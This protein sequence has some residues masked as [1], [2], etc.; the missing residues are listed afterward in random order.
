VSS[1]PPS[2]GEHTTKTFSPWAERLPE[3][4]TPE[5]LF[6]ETKWCSLMSYGLTAELLQEVLPM[7]SALH[8]STIRERSPAV[9]PRCIQSDRQGSAGEDRDG[10]E[11][12]ESRPKVLKHLESIKWYLWHGNTFQAMNTAGSGNGFGVGGCLR[13]KTRTLANS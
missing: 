13:A 12:Y 9:A 2:D 8:A 1:F 10:E 7:D 5:L 6:L 4:T 3:R 11:Q